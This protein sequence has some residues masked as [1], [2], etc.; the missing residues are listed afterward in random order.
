[1]AAVTNFNGKAEPMAAT[2][3]TIHGKVLIQI[4]DGE[5]VEVGKISIPITAGPAPVTNMPTYAPGVR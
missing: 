3:G 2:L 1:M 5:P 4:G